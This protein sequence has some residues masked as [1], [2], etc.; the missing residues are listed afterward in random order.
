MSGI[1]LI[2][3]PPWA[4]V[5]ANVVWVQAWNWAAMPVGSRS[6]IWSNPSE[7]SSESVSSAG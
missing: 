1:T 6:S 2:L 7:D 5:G 3:V 4:T